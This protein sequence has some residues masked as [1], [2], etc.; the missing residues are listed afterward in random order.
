VT[1]TEDT[2][3][4]RIHAEHEYDLGEAKLAA[5]TA[6]AFLSRY[7]SATG[8]WWQRFVADGAV[9]ETP[10]PHT[11]AGDCDHTTLNKELKQR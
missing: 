6:Y 8:T 4:A 2:F 5:G 11:H 7:Q 9:Y 1:L 10:C 3:A